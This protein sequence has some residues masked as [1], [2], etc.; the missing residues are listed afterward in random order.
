MH[1]ASHSK[2]SFIHGNTYL[3]KLTNSSPNTPPLK[4]RKLESNF[5]WFMVFWFILKKMGKDLPMLR[6]RA[7][8]RP[9]WQ[10]QDTTPRK[11]LRTGVWGLVV[12]KI[13]HACVRQEDV[14]C[15]LVSTVFRGKRLGSFIHS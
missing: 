6:K 3:I 10:S 2:L 7:A 14:S 1:P 15:C 11:V 12:D 8:K 4:N 13:K 9:Q 5:I